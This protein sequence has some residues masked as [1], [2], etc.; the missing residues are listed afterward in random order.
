MNRMVTK[1]GQMRI[2]QSVVF[3]VLL[4]MTLPA[5]GYVLMGEHVLDLMVKSFGQA[6]TLEVTQSVTLHGNAT[7]LPSAPLQ[8]TVRIRIPYDFRAD[9]SGD[10]F[11]RQ[12]IISGNTAL[13]AINGVM[14]KG[15]LPGYARYADILMVKPRQALADHLR[16][17]GID[18]TVSSLGRLE[19]RYCYVIGAQYP[20]EKAAQ[21]WVAKDT[22]RPVRLMLP[23]SARQPDAGPVEIRYRNW[24]FVDGTAYPMHILMMKNHQIME[25]I[26]VDRIQVD[27]QF[28][29]DL[30][31]VMALRQEWSEPVA[32]DNESGDQ[33]LNPNDSPA[34]E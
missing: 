13:L 21:L 24:G 12:M 25:E 23:P 22:F 16:M 30:F 1:S 28:P 27:P 7:P 8:E 18:V 11:R 31:D 9:A 5:R 4:G 15:P 6:T 26:R 20:D 19:E 34:M 2:L 29:D 17:L 10:N 32:T 33:I 14:Q 3:A